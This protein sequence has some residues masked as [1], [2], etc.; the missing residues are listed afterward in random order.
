M[1]VASVLTEMTGPSTKVGLITHRSRSSF[2]A[3]SQAACSA[4]VCRA[5]QGEVDCRP[6]SWLTPV[7]NGMLCPNQ[8]PDSHLSKAL[9]CVQ[10]PNGGPEQRLRR[11]SPD[12]A[13]K[14]LGTME[15]CYTI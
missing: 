12:V 5:L 14:W 4:T 6:A 3:M 15:V 7:L 1:L 13:I 11:E 8:E 2:F 10:T 9:E